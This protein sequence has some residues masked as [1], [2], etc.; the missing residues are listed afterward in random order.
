MSALKLPTWTVRNTNMPKLKKRVQAVRPLTGNKM[1]D[2]MFCRTP[3]RTDI[4]TTSV[5]CGACVSRLADPP[6]RVAAPVSPEVKAAR[7][8][9]RVERKAERVAAKAAAPKGR[10]R[11]W[12]LK[13]LFMWE[14]QAYSFGKPISAKEATKLANA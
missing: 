2:C 12:H 14:G 10:G 13:R 3:T 4:N 11:G 5:L 8:Q 6:A 7:K 9:E 1:L